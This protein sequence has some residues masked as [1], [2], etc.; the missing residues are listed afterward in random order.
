MIWCDGLFVM[1]S[2]QIRGRSGP[3]LPAIEGCLTIQLTVLNPPLPW[4]FLSFEFLES[5]LDLTS[6]CTQPVAFSTQPWLFDL[7]RKISLL[8]W[9]VPPQMFYL[10][11]Y[12]G[13]SRGNQC[14]WKVLLQSLH[15]FLF[16]SC[17]PW[18][19]FWTYL[20]IF[21]CHHSCMNHN[22]S[23]SQRP[24]LL[25]TFYW[26]GKN[27]PTSLFILKS[28]LG[29]QLVIC[30]LD[31]SLFKGLISSFV[32]TFITFLSIHYIKLF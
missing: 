20:A 8:C 15:I 27:L 11:C 29:F 1:T 3:I 30:A 9:S 21:K 2:I 25:R 22:E 5:T 7:A 16:L 14:Q 24:S 26:L 13:E 10:Q 17:F 6:F 28:T 12:R 19:L 31:F 18:Q 23:Y 4:F 32:Y